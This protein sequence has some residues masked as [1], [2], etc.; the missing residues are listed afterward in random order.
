MLTKRRHT[1]PIPKGATVFEE[2]GRRYAKWYTPAGKPRLRPLNRKGDRLVYE[3][4]CWYVRLKDPDTGKYREWRAFTDRQASRAREIELLKMLERGEV[5]IVDT[6]AEHRKKPLDKHLFDFEAYMEDKGN[7]HEHIDKTIARC[8]RIVADISAK[9]FGDI[10]AERVDECL[11]RWRRQDMSVGTSNGYFRAMRAFCRW[12]VRARRCRQNPLAGMSCIKVTDANRT[13]KRRPLTDD[14]VR[15]LIETTRKS[16]EPFM[17]LS[18]EDRAM[19]YLIAVN[20]GLRASELASLTPES[21]E[22]DGPQPAVR[23]QGGYTKNGQEAELPLRRDIAEMVQAWLAGKP[24]GQPLWPGKWAAQRHGAEML[25]IDLTAADIDAEDNRGRVVDFHALR[26]TFIS[27]L[28]RAGVHP[29]NAQALAR[30]STIDLTMNV[31]TH[32]EMKDLANDV[33]NLPSVFGGSSNEAPASVPD[34]LASLATKW[35]K[36][37]DHVKQAIATLAQA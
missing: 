29:R 33:E 26:H 14:E 1:R 35:A 17:D 20:T 12:M 7:T 27:N 25:R 23:C 21:V 6:L 13:R 18:G 32:V 31:Y 30:H 11:A 28:A 15:R 24:E 9:R 4:E 16:P 8:K 37:P 3:S 2:D 19:L 36:L 22:I 10:T 34:D 5:G